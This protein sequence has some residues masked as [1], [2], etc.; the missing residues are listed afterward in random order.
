M[1]V[2]PTVTTKSPTAIVPLLRKASR[3][4]RAT[5]RQ[6]I[7]SAHTTNELPQHPARHVFARA[8]RRPAPVPASAPWPPTGRDVIDMET[9]AT[10]TGDLSH[11]SW[12][13]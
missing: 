9:I 5:R 7:L 12:L 11:G 4:N 3:I 1:G 6:Y 8:A 13:I 10:Q 2:T